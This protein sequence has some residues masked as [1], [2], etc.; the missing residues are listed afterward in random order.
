[1]SSHVGIIYRF[2]N[3]D[4]NI[5]LEKKP[6]KKTRNMSVESQESGDQTVV[7]GVG[8]VSKLPHV[9]RRVSLNIMCKYRQFLCNNYSQIYL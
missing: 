7:N 8:G 5:V 6:S 3:F 4:D 1:M 2:R 9:S